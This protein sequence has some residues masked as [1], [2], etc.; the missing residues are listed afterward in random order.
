[1]GEEIRRNQYAVKQGLQILVLHRITG[2]VW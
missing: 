2:F 1:M